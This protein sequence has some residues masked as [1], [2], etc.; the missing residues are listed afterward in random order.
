[1]W[2]Y[3]HSIESGAPVGVIF[4][5]FEEVEKWPEWNPG[6]ERMEIDGPFRSGTSGRMTMPGEAPIE[7]KLVWVDP[8]A[9]FE[10]ETEI[11]G[12]GV[13]VRVRH[14]LKPL[15]AGTRITYAVSITG[16]MA[17][18]LGPEIGPQITADFPQVMSALCERAEAAVS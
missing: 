16:P 2:E 11:P 8:A 7:T 3:E 15:E 9:G 14:T 6:V 5:I 18:S 10:D 13:V 1:M 4:A 12:A 17:D